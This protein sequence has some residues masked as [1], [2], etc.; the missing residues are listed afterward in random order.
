MKF[1]PD[2]ARDIMLAVEALEPNEA[3]TIPQLAEMY[4]DYSEDVLNYHCLK[5]YEAGMITGAAVPVTRCLLPQVA[6]ITSLTYQG[7]QL[8]EDIRT[9]TTWKKAKDIASELG[10]QSIHALAGIAASVVK[11]KIFKH[12]NP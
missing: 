7:H 4:P 5:L 8:L 12:F 3:L 11:A 2:C 6:R 10:V 9:D 1:S